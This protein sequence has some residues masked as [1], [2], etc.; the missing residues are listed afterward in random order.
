MLR[1]FMLES[2]FEFS[3]EALQAAFKT[4][5]LPPQIE[6][7]AIWTLAALWNANHKWIEAHAAN[8]AKALASTCH[9]SLGLAPENSASLSQQLGSFSRADANR[10]RMAVDGGYKPWRTCSRASSKS[11]T[12]PRPNLEQTGTWEGPPGMLD[13]VICSMRACR[14][15]LRQV[16]PLRAALSNLLRP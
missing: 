12:L 9:G 4:W 10:T 1:V 16:I 5:R 2:L 14:S 15:C 13:A 8:Q 3:R 7:S 6:L 11:S